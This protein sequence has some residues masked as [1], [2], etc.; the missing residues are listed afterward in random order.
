MRFVQ[1][2]NT[3]NLFPPL[4]T[5][6]LGKS[7]LLIPFYWSSKLEKELACIRANQNIS[8]HFPFDRLQMLVTE[9]LSNPIH[10]EQWMVDLKVPNKY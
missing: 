8:L 9:K 2:C 5:L 7:Y 6:S 10:L 1:N 3:V 4:P